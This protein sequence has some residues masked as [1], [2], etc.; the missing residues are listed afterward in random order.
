MTGGC[1]RSS[2]RDDQ[3]VRRPSPTA[4]RP[5]ERC[6]RR[7]VAGP[8]RRDCQRS[9]R[10][11]ATTARTPGHRW[12]QAHGR[13]APLLR[14]RPLPA[15]VPPASWSFRC[16]AH[17]PAAVANRIPSTPVHPSGNEARPAPGDAPRPSGRVALGSWAVRLPAPCAA[18]L[19]GA[20]SAGSWPRICCVTRSSFED[21]SIPS[22]S[23]SRARN[24]RCTSNA[25]GARPAR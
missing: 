12:R 7:L 20:S 9:S 16:P 14:G 6:R 5:A 18:E 19:G 22:S 8:R 2:V 24:L 11:P 13:C 1:H 4:G 10:R 25:S 21:G 23:R 15:R 3:S 17:R